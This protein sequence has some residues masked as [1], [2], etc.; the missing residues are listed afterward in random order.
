MAFT[1][2]LIYWPKKDQR[3][4]VVT[5][6]KTKLIITKS[7]KTKDD[8]LL[9]LLRKPNWNKNKIGKENHV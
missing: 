6:N 3:D 4:Q 1:F 8:Q 9:S 5:I 7:F 2:P